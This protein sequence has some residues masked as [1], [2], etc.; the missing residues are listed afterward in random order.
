VRVAKFTFSIRSKR[1]KGWL[2][3]Y[4]QVYDGKGHRTETYLG[5]HGEVETERA[6]LRKK[7]EYFQGLLQEI[8]QM[9]KETKM[10]LEQLPKEEAET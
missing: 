3:D 7:L 8:Q 9:V 2:Y 4:F 1:V 5:R 6:T 10:Q